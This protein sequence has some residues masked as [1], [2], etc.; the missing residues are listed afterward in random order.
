MAAPDVNA[1]WHKGRDGGQLC[2][3]IA[4]DGMFAITAPTGPDAQ[5][6]LAEFQALT[7]ERLAAF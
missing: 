7:L 1:S 4:M 6:L 3:T 5:P 2:G